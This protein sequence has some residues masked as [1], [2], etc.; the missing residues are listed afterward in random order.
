MERET[1]GERADA[2]PG[3]IAGIA[4]LVKNMFGLAASR[5]E[6]AAFELGEIRGKLAR[7]AMMAALGVI[8]I[9]FA[10]ACWTAL[11]VVIAWETW[12]WKIL[13]LLAILFTL[14]GIGILAYA[15][16]LLRGDWLSM[17]HTLAELRKDRDAFL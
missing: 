7:L 8:A 9:W 12:G 17:P 3:L 6:L 1:A 13:L 11:V 16:S 4:G 5:I 2:N 10:V 14:A 15:K